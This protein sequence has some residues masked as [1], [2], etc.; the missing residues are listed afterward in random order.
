MVSRTGSRSPSGFVGTTFQ[1]PRAKTSSPVERPFSAR[2]DSADKVL[3]LAGR[4]RRGPGCRRGDVPSTLRRT[5]HDP[6]RS[7]PVRPRRA[8]AGRRRT[9]P[10]VRRLDAGAL[11]AQIAEHTGI[12]L[13]LLG[14]APGG[15]VGAAYVRW[16]DGRDGVLTW[17]SDRSP[18]A[19][20]RLRRTAEVLRFARSH[21]LATPTYDL[22]AE[23]PDAVAI[24]QERL[25]GA[26][27][28]RID[29]RL[30]D[31]MLAVNERCAGL[32]A[33]RPDT[34]RPELYLDRSGPG[35]C[36]HESL[37]AYD[38]RTRRLLARVHQI[39]RDS[40][41]PMRG[42]DLVHLDFHPGNV[43]VDPEGR[44]TGVI[45]WDALGRGD[46]RFD[47]VTLRFTIA[48]PDRDVDDDTLRLYWAHL[49]LRMVDWAIR[50]WSEAEITHWLEVSHL[51][52]R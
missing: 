39:G 26:S 5:R 38:R 3:P 36:L 41:G 49:S 19:G 34:P 13:E 12:R 33:D 10:P 25:P 43:L 8:V 35:F 2:L 29:R 15:E 47:L 20:R 52:L 1:A 51:G 24:V 4:V 28:T 9:P 27:P 30:V 6:N 46:R 48:A 32:L 44:L 40:P 7:K 31:G 22:V 17:Q 18:E 37:E 11:I 23:L 14:Y 21:G 50:H 42:D 45:D 16:S